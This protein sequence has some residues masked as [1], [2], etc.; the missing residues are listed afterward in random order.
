VLFLKKVIR[1]GAS[2]SYGVDVAK[3]AG[4]PNVVLD[5]ARQYLVGLEQQTEDK[6]QQVGF[7]FWAINDTYKKLHDD[8][9]KELD[10]YNVNEI[11]PIEALVKLQ[12]IKKLLGK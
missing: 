7:N 5:M 3:L 10:T 6:P 9:H 12:E 2:K 11:T 1:W 8:L 4:V